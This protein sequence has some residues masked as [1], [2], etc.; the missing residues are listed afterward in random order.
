M[1][2]GTAAAVPFPIILQE[3]RFPA[4]PLSAC[5]ISHAGKP[6]AAGISCFCCAPR[7]FRRALYII[8]EKK[9]RNTCASHLRNGVRFTSSSVT[10]RLSS[11]VAQMSSRTSRTMWPP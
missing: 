8:G 7:I 11:S 2:K 10:S 5:D 1:G 3:H 4:N 6:S 9:R